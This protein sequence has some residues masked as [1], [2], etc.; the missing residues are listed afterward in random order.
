MP[1]STDNKA[2]DLQMQCPPFAEKNGRKQNSRNAK[3]KAFRE[4]CWKERAGLRKLLN[5]EFLRILGGFFRGKEV[6]EN[7]QPFFQLRV[8]FWGAQGNPQIGADVMAGRRNQETL[9]VQDGNAMLKGELF[10]VLHGYAMREGK[11]AEKAVRIRMEFTFPEILL[12]KQVALL[13]NLPFLR[14]DFLCRPIVYHLD[15]DFRVQSGCLDID[16]EHAVDQRFRIAFRKYGKSNA[17]PGTEGFG[18]RM[19]IYSVFRDK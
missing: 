5:D 18:K 14:N 3:R 10:H 13:Q 6:F 4:F 16:A 8:C 17:Q 12:I 9:A 7:P 2:L 15:K 11:P 1:Y 19:D